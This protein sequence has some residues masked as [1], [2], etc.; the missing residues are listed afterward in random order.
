MEVNTENYFA[1]YEL[2]MSMQIDLD[3]L[4]SKYY[5]YSKTFHP[6]FFLQASEEQQQQVMELAAFNNKA[7]KTLQEQDMRLQYLLQIQGVIQEGEKH[8]LQ[9]AFLM[10]MMEINEELMDLQMDPDPSKLSEIKEKISDYESEI[11]SVIQPQLSQKD[12][13]KCSEQEL[14]QVKEYYYKKKYLRRIQE[15]LE[16]QAPQ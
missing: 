4:Q 1:F 6:D 16:Q 5:K 12:L 11:E 8:Q 14:L 10:E 2:P 3:E 7:Y 15:T 13:T 9:P